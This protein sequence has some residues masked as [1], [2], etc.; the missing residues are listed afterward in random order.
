MDGT[1]AGGCSGRN[2]NA[3]RCVA[4]KPDLIKSDGGG[5]PWLNELAKAATS[6]QRMEEAATKHTELI[7]ELAKINASTHLLVLNAD[8]GGEGNTQPSKEQATKCKPQNAT[9][10]ECPD[11]D[12]DY[13]ANAEDGKK[14]KAKP[15]AEN[16]V[17]GTYGAAA[18][19][20]EAKKC[21]N[22][23]KEEE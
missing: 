8:Y 3:G 11:T 12:C 1:G 16:T 20:S 4:Y 10:A 18:T 13:D 19:N 14:C 21:S 7:A 2:S 17:V 23:K 15:G 9:P 6:T 5:I 22:K